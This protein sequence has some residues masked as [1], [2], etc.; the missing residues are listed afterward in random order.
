MLRAALADNPLPQ[1]FAGEVK[2]KVSYEGV[3]VADPTLK[4][5]NQQVEIRVT[6]ENVSTNILATVPLYPSVAMGE[7]VRVSGT[8]AVPEAFMDDN[9]RI[10]N[11]EK[12]LERQGIRFTMFASL[13]EVSAPPWYS[14]PALFAGIKHRFLSGIKTALPEPDASLA[15][16]LV[17]G[18]KSGLGTDLL[19][20]FT[21]S[22]LV[23]IIVLSGY[24]VMV[25]AE[26]VLIALGS[27]TLK[28]KSVAAAAAAAVILFV[29][30]AGVSSTA[31]R[32]LLMALVAL[33]ARATG[34]SYAASRALLVV[35]FLMLLWRPLIL[36]FDPS[37]DLS[38]AA[39]AGLIWLSPLIELK[40]TKIKSEFWRGSVA[41]TLAAQLA[42]WPLLLYDTGNLSLVS[43]PANLLVLPFIPFAMA[44]S[45]VAGVAGM[46]FGPLS[47]ILGFPAYLS[48]RFLIGVARLASTLPAIVLPAF[49]FA[50]V[51]AAYALL[52]F[53][54]WSKR[55][56]MT[57]QLRL[58]KKA[59]I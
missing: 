1:P 27:L 45:A 8:L 43:I 52:A 14:L 9:G 36:A 2:Q 50:F 32:A 29:L 23:Q 18:G 24:N 17:I 31:L 20:D 57:V 48:T 7:R 13:R 56:S 37:F 28:K 44:A 12:Y 42:V 6:E 11:Y 47:F 16:G 38:V 41:T 30:I 54:A 19:A 49:P 40:L 51:L 55:S 25:V 34:R 58:S 21:R 33:Y 3:V 10:F 4:D 5:A 15:G 39:T 35:I 46:I 59:P 53:I 22:G 26:G